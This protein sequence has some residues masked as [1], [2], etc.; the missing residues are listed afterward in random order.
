MTDITPEDPI[1][2]QQMVV[3]HLVYTIRSDLTELAVMRLNP[4][5]AHYLMSEEAN[6][7]A[8]L[9]ALQMLLSHMSAD[10]PTLRLV[11]R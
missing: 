9:T 6:L 11:K 4:K 2:T 3:E 7:G 8:C 1:D 10:R 5:T